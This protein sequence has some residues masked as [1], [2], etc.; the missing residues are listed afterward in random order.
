ME[1]SSVCTAA[2]LL[3][4][5]VFLHEVEVAVYHIPHLGYSNLVVARISEHLGSPA[6]WRKREKMKRVAELS[7]SQAGAVDVV[8]VGLVDDDSVGH[9]HDAALDSLELVACAGELDEQ[10]EVDHRMDGC[11]ALA[12]SDCLEIK[13][14]LQQKE[15]RVL[16]N[17]QSSFTAAHDVL[18]RY[19]EILRS[20]DCGK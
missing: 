11:L 15:M 7:L 17:E 3:E 9:L 2:F 5:A 1:I 18:S 19:F 6:T 20:R 14:L 16:N 4:I 13:A 10:E 12:H 8:A